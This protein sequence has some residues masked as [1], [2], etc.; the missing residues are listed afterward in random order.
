LYLWSSTIILG[1]A[2][3]LPGSSYVA[4]QSDDCTTQD[5]SRSTC[6]RLLPRNVVAVL[7]LYWQERM[8]A[9]SVDMSLFVR[10]TTRAEDA[11]IPGNAS[12]N[13][14]W[15]VEVSL[16]QAEQTFLTVFSHLQL[17]APR[18]SEKLVT[19]QSF[20]TLL[21]FIGSLVSASPY[22]PGAFAPSL[23]CECPLVNCVNS[24]PAVCRTPLL[25]YYAD[26][27][28][29]LQAL[30]R[31]INDSEILCKR[32]CPSHVAKITVGVAFH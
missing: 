31:C 30:C 24:N 4:F 13:S 17:F 1:L 32:R 3:A 5:P 12:E 26:Y 10:K 16:Q 8:A 18:N 9:M 2:T 21:P 22:V 7:D 23:P 19:M 25:L 28:T 27:L 6:N 11:K 14:E 20:L 29:Y 15:L